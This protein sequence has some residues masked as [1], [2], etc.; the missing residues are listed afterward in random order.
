MRRHGFT[1]L[2][3]MVTVAIIGILATAAVFTMRSAGRNA[4]LSSA[5]SELSLLMSG[6]STVA[7]SEGRDQ[8]LVFTDAAGNDASGCGWTNLAACSRYF[9]LDEPNQDWELASFDATSPQTD[10]T[11]VVDSWVMPRGVQLHE[12]ST[13]VPPAPFSNITPFD[14]RYTADCPGERRCFAV[15]FTAA[16]DVLPEPAIDP[17]P[18]VPAPGYAIVLVGGAGTD[19]GADRRAVLLTSPSGI[20]KS[21]SVGQ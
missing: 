17:P 13:A 11:R 19:T 16:G 8:L 6:L 5:A 15:R 1:L 20:V 10:V 21:F 12:D 18:T 4:D 14:S 2:E 9:H 7:L 3:V